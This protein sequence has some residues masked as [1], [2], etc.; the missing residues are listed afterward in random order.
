[1]RFDGDI[2]SIDKA[3]GFLRGYND[4]LHN[5]GNEIHPANAI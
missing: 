1:M 2:S 5:L 4:P 3:F